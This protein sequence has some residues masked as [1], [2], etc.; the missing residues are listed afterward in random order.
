MHEDKS[1]IRKN[2]FSHA[3]AEKSRIIQDK[4]RRRLIK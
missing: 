1:D 2:E 3:H 4:F